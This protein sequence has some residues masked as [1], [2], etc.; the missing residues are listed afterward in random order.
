M[1]YAIERDEES[2]LALLAFAGVIR[3][4]DRNAALAELGVLFAATGWR[5]VLVDFSSSTS[6]T[7]T[8]LQDALRHAW[9]LIGLQAEWKDLRVAYIFS[10]RQPPVLE[11]IAASRGYVFEH[12]ASRSAALGWLEA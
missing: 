4:E 8:T 10:P 9:R 12:F 2:K 5:K 7:A 11:L 6:S 3:M 1:P